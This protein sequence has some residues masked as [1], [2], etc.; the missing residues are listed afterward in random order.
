MECSTVV[1]AINDDKTT[2]FVYV[3]QNNV[4]DLLFVFAYLVIIGIIMI[5]GA[6][7]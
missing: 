7:Y 3:C 5:G 1:D 2:S 6:K 4:T